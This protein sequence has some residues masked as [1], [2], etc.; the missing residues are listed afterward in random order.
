[1]VGIFNQ[2]KS[3]II[4]VINELLGKIAD[5]INKILNIPKIPNPPVGG[6]GGGGGGGGRGPIP[7]PGDVPLM[8]TGGVIPANAPFAAILGD[9][10]YGRNLEAPEGLIRQIVREETG[11]LQTQVTV[12]FEGDLAS[13]VRELK[14]HIDAETK[15]VGRSLAKSVA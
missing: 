15:R 3:S 8:A 1:V 11:R 7:K 2:I 13:L 12:R 14:P 5:L 9:Q 6:G 10:R 4:G